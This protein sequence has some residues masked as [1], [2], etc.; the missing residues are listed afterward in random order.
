MLEVQLLGHLALADS[1]H[2]VEA[3]RNPRLI[4]YLLL[5]R[6]RPLERTEVAFTLWPD[7]SDA[8][9]LTNLR[10]ELHA[11]RRALP[12]AERLLAIE[13]RTIRW[14]PD[15]PFHLDVAAFEDAVEHAAGGSVDGLRAAVAI[16]RGDLLPG[17]Y[18]D[19][20]EPHRDHL[21]TKMLETLDALATGLEDR[22]EYR[23]AMEQ[24][25][26]L[27]V[28]DPLAESR[29]QALMRV[30]ALVGDRTAGLRAYH[31]CVSA[32]RDELGIEPSRETLNAYQRLVTLDVSQV[33]ARAGSDVPAQPELVG[34]DPEW[35]ALVDG[36]NRAVNGALTLALIQG[37]AGIGKSRL[38]E[39]F[40]RWARAQGATVLTARSWAV[41]GSLA[42]APVTAWL[43][44]A[45]LRPLLDSLDDV[46]LSEISRL[47]PE[48]LA[49]HPGLA[50]PAPMLESWQRQRLFEAL[51]RAV[52]KARAQ[53]LLVLD[54][55]NWTDSDTL[56]WLHFTL[57]TA[58]VTGFVILGA[59]SGEVESNRALA[60]LV[61]DARNRAELLDIE[62]GPLS[63]AE[64]A[65]LAA[66]TT[67]RP[68]DGAA[69]A[70]LYHE[71]EGHPLFVVE[72][73]RSG[74]AGTAEPDSVGAARSGP[75]PV[76]ARMT[77]RMRAV[78]AA[79]L[80]QLT[81]TAQRVVELAAAIGR[82]FDVDVLAASAD[83]DEPDLVE[84]LDELW[85]RR[86]IRE[87]GLNRYDF[88][89]DRIREVAYDQIAPAGRRV[90]HRRVAQALELRHH[91]DIDPIAAQLAA[92]LESAGLGLRA[93]GLYE[94]AAAVAARVLASAEATRHLSRALAILA[95]SPASRDRDVL[96]LRLLLLLSP[97]L[98]AI[99]GY[100]SRRQEATVDR[101]RA[102]A[103]ELGEELDELFALNGLWAVSV[104]GGDVDR[105]LEVAEAAF[106]RSDGHP[107]FASASH[108]AMGGSLTFLGEQEKAVIEFKQ[109]IATY[110]P[111]ASRPLTSGTDPGVFALSWGAHAL[112]LEGR[113][114]T[115]SKWSNRA[116]ALAD[117]LDGPY[118]TMIAQSYAAIL[119]QIRGDVEAMLEH[120][121][122]AAELCSQYGFAYYREWPVIL[123][124]WADR[125]VGS[126]S[127]TR[128]ERALDELRSIRGL[129]RRPY[130]LSLLADAHQA[131]GHPRQARA[132]LDAAL[133]DAATSGEQW[134]VP[135]LHRRL[136][137]LD[138]G[139]GG[140]VAVRRAVD[141]ATAQGAWSLTLRAAIS[142]ARRAP[143]EQ[144]TLRAVLD[145]VPE[146]ARR[147][148]LE[149]E[150]VLAG[151]VGHASTNASANAS[152]T[153]DMPASR[154]ISG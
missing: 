150:A 53:P 56:E 117:S 133:A 106:R 49:D 2:H 95:E 112:W 105:S 59:R 68:L 42:Y 31:A 6:D 13:R 28:I 76:P 126:D 130:Y 63:E 119:D 81:P 142:L 124:A 134:W 145:A 5:N 151:T 27:V 26:R 94:R 67:D 98:L 139:L 96:E 47:L 66:A 141:L 20:I 4:A 125:G 153:I 144:A 14:R 35:K 115:A 70:R 109:A 140:E 10:R 121:T 138:D 75:L 122:V 25:S 86:I 58:A 85:R 74:L 37:D 146:P 19:W 61:S 128:I 39:E 15:G 12:D 154:P 100:A 55:A 45:P 79:R 89:H 43:R 80:H 127:P 36:W 101:A 9:A 82:D 34:R 16:Y 22:R 21:R 123:A 57:R 51:A 110:V 50:G 48:L 152:R 113:T 92:Q 102:L 23:A 17:V 148:R 29:Y 83:L 111:G 72:M 33:P 18:D 69:H 136:G 132:V 120:A 73:A 62:L 52:G 40:S 1:G 46:W 87:H 60:S 30:A 129:A 104:V 147:D 71:T 143:S 97:S 108:L 90:L 114:A 149:A 103:A 99:E 78:I 41:E 116:I 91:D 11:L 7:S 64:T 65:T 137:T 84:G 54:D 38:I 118:M 93:C 8:Q 44:S 131:A 24:L 32:L 135:E 88:S 107:D 3:V 77:A